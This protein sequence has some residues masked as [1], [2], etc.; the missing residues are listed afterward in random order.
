MSQAQTNTKRSGSVPLPSAL[1]RGNAHWRPQMASHR[2]DRVAEEFLILLHP[3]VRR[4][5]AAIRDTAF[6]LV[7]MRPFPSL[8]QQRS[9]DPARS[10]QQPLRSSPGQQTGAPAEQIAAG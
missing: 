9:S 6:P 8:Q 10:S 4:S 5:E 7:Q 2:G 3:A 1:L